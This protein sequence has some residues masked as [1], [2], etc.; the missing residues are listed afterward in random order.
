MNSFLKDALT[1]P[2]TAGPSVTVSGSHGA[3][4]FLSA[5]RLLGITTYADFRL[6]V[7]FFFLL[8]GVWRLHPG[9]GGELYS[10]VKSAHWECV[11][12]AGL[13]CAM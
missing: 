7:C 2:T 5:H 1:V 6:V 12:T 11:T 13:Q 4:L 9:S 10:D 8:G 3:S